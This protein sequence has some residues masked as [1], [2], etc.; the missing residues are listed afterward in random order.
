[1][2][3]QKPSLVLGDPKGCAQPP[4]PLLGFRS[5]LGFGLCVSRGLSPPLEWRLWKGGYVPISSPAASLPWG[6]GDPQLPLQML[7]EGTHSS[8]PSSK[9]P[10]K[11]PA[12]SKDSTLRT[13]TEGPWKNLIPQVQRE[14]PPHLFCHQMSGVRFHLL[15][16]GDVMGHLSQLRAPRGPSVMT[17]LGQ[18]L[19]TITKHWG[20]GPSFP[21]GRIPPPGRI[22]AGRKHA[23]ANS[24]SAFHRSVASV[25]DSL[26]AQQ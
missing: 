23:G 7:V 20:N 15:S 12:A 11:L 10:G 24:I 9:G 3:H 14:T 5:R 21:A 16:R 22:P 2:P 19:R 18:G 17:T 6:P 25:R 13:G 8:P 4:C 1:M 26:V